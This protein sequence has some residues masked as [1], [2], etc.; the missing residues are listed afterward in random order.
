MRV[1]WRGSNSNSWLLSEL[2]NRSRQ[3]RHRSPYLTSQVDVGQV[4]AMA[5]QCWQ[6]DLTKSM[7]RDPEWPV[8]PNSQACLHWWH[9]HRCPSVVLAATFSCACMHVAVLT[10]LRHCVFSAGLNSRP[11]TTNE[12]SFF[13][14][15]FLFSPRSLSFRPLSH[16]DRRN[17]LHLFLPSHLSAPGTRHVKRKEKKKNRWCSYKH[18]LIASL[19]PL[20]TSTEIFLNYYPLIR[21]DVNIYWFDFSLV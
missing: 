10:E 16:R 13:S 5:G 11:S 21:I 8:E 7:F 9:S 18:L 19:S 4:I 20:E 3:L 15:S 17:S 6:A 1:G 2:C 12:F 14:S